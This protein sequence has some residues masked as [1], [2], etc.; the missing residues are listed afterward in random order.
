M[1]GGLGERRVGA[2]GGHGGTGL[3]VQ[4]RPHGQRQ[5]REHQQAAGGDPQVDADAVQVNGQEVGQQLVIEALQRDNGTQAGTGEAPHHGGMTVRQQQPHHAHEGHG[6][7]A[8]VGGDHHFAAL[9]L[10]QQP[11]VAAAEQQREGGGDQD[12]HHEAHGAGKAELDGQRGAQQ[13]GHDAQRQAEVQAAAGM[14][15]GNHGQHQNGVPAEAVDGIGDLG[16]QIGAHDRG[17]DKQQQQE[18]RDDDAGSPKLS[19]SCR[20]FVLLPRLVV[21][22]LPILSSLLHLTDHQHA[23]FLGAMVSRQDTGDLA[24]GDDGDPVTDLTQLFQLGGDHH[25]GDA[26]LAVELLQGLQHQRLGA[27]VDAAGRLGDKEETGLQREGLGKADLLLVAAGQLSC[28]LQGAGALDLK[29]VDV[30][31]GDLMDGPFRHAT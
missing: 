8:H 11:A 2:H 12:R 1:P 15:H 16:G 25:H 20:N 24:A 3:G 26:A 21:T 18:A 4:E 28:L 5:Q 7:E 9:D 19:I 23:E 10:V 22:F 14:D 6:G 30:L 27:H 17:G 31:L 13:A 29:L